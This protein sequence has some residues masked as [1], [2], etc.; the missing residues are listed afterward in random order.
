MA[1]Q[2]DDRHSRGS[3]QPGG[4]RSPLTWLSPVVLAGLLVLAYFTWPAFRTLVDDGWR[5]ASSGDA[6]EVRQW[7]DGFGAWGPIVFYGLMIMQVVVIFVPSVIME[8]AAVMAYGPLWGMVLAWSGGIVAAVFGY[9]VGRMG[10]PVVDALL[11][12]R[13]RNR[14]TRLVDRYGFWAVALVRFSPL[15]SS[16]AI[17]L[18]AGLTEM[19][20]ATFA[21]ATAIGMAPFAALLAILGGSFERLKI[22]FIA[23]SSATIAVFLAYA[24]WSHRRHRRGRQEQ[25]NGDGPR[26][27][28]GE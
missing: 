1:V 15:L 5:V 19:R 26:D 8:I 3:R 21:A 13:G 12:S 9:G 27:S 11:S 17:S 24:L 18:V 6:Q 28:G 23:L 22:G 2:N 4:G 14:V 10:T 16:D 25:E 20:F 7:V